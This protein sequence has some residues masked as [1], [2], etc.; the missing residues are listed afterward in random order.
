[1]HYTSIFL[2]NDNYGIMTDRLY[3][4]FSN[5]INF[6]DSAT[7]YSFTTFTLYNIQY[8]KCKDIYFEERKFVLMSKL[9]LKLRSLKGQCY[10]KFIELIAK[11]F[12]LIMSN[13]T[14]LKN[15]MGLNNLDVIRCRQ[16]FSIRN[17][18]RIY[19]DLFLMKIRKRVKKCRLCDQ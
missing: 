12:S 4:Q 11:Y 2:T 6:I 9:D 18:K 13:Y 7:D 8:T 5:N 17:N 14:S 10:T 16:F 19:R 1:M 3:K 15:C